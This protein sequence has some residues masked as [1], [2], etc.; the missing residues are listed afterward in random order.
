[1]THSEEFVQKVFVLLLCTTQQVSSNV[2]HARPLVIMLKA[3][4][5]CIWLWN[6]Q[7]TQSEK[8]FIY[9]KIQ[10]SRTITVSRLSSDIITPCG[11][12]QRGS[13]GGLGSDGGRYIVS[14][15][16]TVT[17]YRWRLI[18]AQQ[19]AAAAVAVDIHLHNNAPVAKWCMLCIFV[20]GQL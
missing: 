11:E 4:S 3:Y 16:N 15:E 14:P 12:L 1:M 20:A 18:K 5:I 2:F 8:G 19:A 13:Y 7:F 6:I 10:L 17:A 9:I